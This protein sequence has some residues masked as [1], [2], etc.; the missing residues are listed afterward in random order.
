MKK[1]IFGT[2]SAILAVLGL[3]SLKE[4]KTSA[5]TYYWFVINSAGQPLGDNQS[6]SNSDATFR[7][8]STSLLAIISLCDGEHNYQCAVGFTANQ[9]FTTTIGGS[10]VLKTHGVDSDYPFNSQ[11]SKTARTTA[12]YVRSD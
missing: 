3:S 10:K 2:A 4:A 9:I 1:I 6:L 5:T 7:Q 11:T 12:A 8:E